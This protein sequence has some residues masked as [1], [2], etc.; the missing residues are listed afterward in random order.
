MIFLLIRNTALSLSLMSFILSAR[1][2][3]HSEEI[4]SQDSFFEFRA[5]VSLLRIP[6]KCPVAKLNSDGTA[7]RNPENKCSFYAC[8]AE[9]ADQSKTCDLKDKNSYFLNYGE[10]YCERFSSN[11]S[12]DLSQ[13]GQVWLN[14]TLS[15]LQSSILEGCNE[16]K[17]CS[18]CQKIRKLAFDTHPHC[19]VSSGLCSLSLQD[20][21][22][23]GKTV[24]AGDFFTTESIAQ[25][26]SVAAN[27]GTYY[28]SQGLTNATNAMNEYRRRDP[29]FNR[30]VQAQALP[31]NSQ[32]AYARS[33]LAWSR[34]VHY[35]PSDYTDPKV[36]LSKYGRSKA[37]DS[38]SLLNPE[39]I[40]DGNLAV[41]VY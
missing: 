19:Y 17:L 35:V 38:G 15:C 36:S 16:K 21:V 41:T 27:C 7:F 39:S 10:K 2:L 8:A 32:S 26:A 11:T 22:Q 37:K 34:S 28:A 40:K 18:N 20:Q 9:S 3:H 13:S 5:P 31:N 4:Q 24:D 30:Y 25:V 33:S 14:K 29:I 23:V 6:S 12:K 1:S